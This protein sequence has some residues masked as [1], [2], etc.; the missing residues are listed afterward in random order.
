MFTVSNCYIGDEE[1]QTIQSTSK[2]TNGNGELRIIWMW[3][4]F[5]SFSIPEVFT[6]IESF[7]ICLFRKLVMPSLPHFLTIIFFETAHVFGL[8]FLFLSIL[9]NLKNHIQC[10]M[11]CHWV[12]LAPCILSFLSRIKNSSRNIGP[13]TMDA[14][15]VIIQLG[16]PISLEVVESFT[17]QSGSPITWKTWLSPIALFL[18][19]FGWWENYVVPNSSIS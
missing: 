10:I 12:C 13:L 9:P 16:G 5:L 8:S 1:N 18:V 3:A 17:T 2:L 11:I 7:R 15:V 6:F 4:I 14:L 19:S